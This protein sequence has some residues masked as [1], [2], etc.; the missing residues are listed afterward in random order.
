MITASVL[1]SFSARA[2]P[3]HNDSPPAD[4]VHG[5]LWA[6][7]EPALFAYRR[8]V[9]FA[10]VPTPPQPP[11]IYGSSAD[12]TEI[13]RFI[14]A[15]WVHAGLAEAAQPPTL[16]D[17]ATFCRRVYLDLIGIIP[18]LAEA[19]RFLGD[20]RPDKRARLV[21]ELLARSADYADHWTPFWEDAL[22]STNTNNQGGVP[23]RGNY[24]AWIRQ[25]FVEN[26]PFD[27]LA[28][29][30]IDTT[31]PG[32]QTPTI[33]EA[34]GRKT[35]TSYILNETHT[36]TLQSAA[37]TAQVFMGTAM[38][39]ASCHN[40]FENE[41]WPQNRFLAFAGM[42]VGH[43]LE[44]IRC[45]KHSGEFVA[46]QFPFDIP[47]APTDLA[48]DEESRLRRVA[49]LLVDPTNPRF[50][51][52]IVN[53]LWKRY[54][55]LGLVEPADDFREDVPP[56]HP[57]LL[58]WLVYD[59]MAHDS[60]LKHTIRRILNSRTY[61]LTYNPALE[62]HFDLA[63]KHDPRLFRSPTLR[64][65]TAEQ[66]V[67]SIL[68][69]TTQKLEPKQRL[70]L[71]NESTALS[72]ALAKPASRNEI[73]TARADDLAVVQSLELLNG[74]EFAREV[75]ASPLAAAS[76]EPDRPRAERTFKAALTR[77]PSAAELDALTEYLHS[78]ADRAALPTKLPDA[79][80][81]DD[82]LPEGSQPTGKWEWH[83]ATSG[84]VVQ[85]RRARTQSSKKHIQHY[86]MNLPRTPV[87]P[88]DTIS[89]RVFL[90]P[91]D[92]PRQIMI[93]FNDG[94]GYDGGWPH[95]AF[96]GSD[97]IPFGQLN[98]QSRLRMGDLPKPGEWVTLNIPALDL[99]FTPGLAIVGMSFDQVAGTVHWDAVSI[100]RGEPTAPDQALGDILWSLFASP[101]F[102]YIH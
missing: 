27:L 45:E 93:Q 49:Q 14:V 48:P 55:G 29:Q 17:D 2:Q 75:Y 81:L 61:Q 56:S 102:Q 18:T 69:A 24:R 66:I 32:A 10:L 33:A 94:V 82:D 19:E 70:Y 57:E 38:K 11:I 47:A 3:S 15:H 35:R 26:R 4:R 36:M 25:A 71:K 92:P 86:V 54:L 34:N 39:C 50:A 46:A 68:V 30:L 9:R 79:T 37:A 77:A 8:A 72:R 23:S 6:S 53:R 80:L 16:C 22:G 40:H 44:R 59:F 73:A 64:R 100:T 52:A 60:D 58:E 51:K 31:I 63:R 21:D 84:T 96:W 42:F 91:D 1:G 95:R 5:L 67:D 78:A 43:D 65:L 13:D 88:N 101:E 7:N 97:E 20:T 28:A 12:L 76:T 83:E 41:E 62:D 90:D 99:G 89:F 98:T 74:E 85:G 87:E